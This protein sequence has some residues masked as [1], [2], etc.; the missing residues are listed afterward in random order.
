MT[1]DKIKEIVVKAY[2]EKGKPELNHITEYKK[3]I[4]EIETET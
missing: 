4:D 1:Y 3:L 2:E